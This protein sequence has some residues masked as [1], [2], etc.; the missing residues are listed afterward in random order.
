MNTTCPPHL[1][2]VVPEST[3]YPVPSLP[4]AFT[5]AAPVFQ[6]C[7][8]SSFDP[9][10]S[11]VQSQ[12]FSQVPFSPVSTNSHRGS[13]ST[14]SSHS[15]T[16]PELG[17]PASRSI[18]IQYLS[19]DTTSQQL[20]EYLRS[21]GTVDRCE[22][23]ER[24]PVGGRPRIFATATFQTKE[25]AKRAIALFDNSIFRGAKIRMRFDRDFGVAGPSGSAARTTPSPT[26]YSKSDT[27]SPTPAMKESSTP[28]LRPQTENLVTTGAKAAES[29]S[30][31]RNTA[32]PLV[33][34][35][36]S[37][38]LKAGRSKV[39]GFG[40]EGAVSFPSFPL[41]PVSRS[42]SLTWGEG[43]FRRTVPENPR[44][45][46]VITRRFSINQGYFW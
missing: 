41:A 26:I 32:G 12:R 19:L 42:S 27:H 44:N 25:E 30:P 37:V 34:N 15:A 40:Y 21:A 8:F 29:S 14:H 2:P 43:D 38:G 20:R 1:V 17:T 23:Q 45:Q 28:P 11:A 24:R 35:G 5:G 4:Y 46:T 7:F 31:G 39:D 36:S 3:G 33:V 22:I 9:V 10:P 16:S 6:P 18:F 13:V